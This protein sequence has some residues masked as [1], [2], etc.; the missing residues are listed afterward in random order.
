MILV[1]LSMAVLMGGC[2]QETATG[3]PP[4]RPVRTVIAAKSE[5]GQSVLLTGQVLAEKEIA[6]PFRIGGRIIERKAGVGDRVKPDQVLAKLD[7]RNELNA[8]R[9]ARAALSAAE[10]RLTQDAHRRRPPHLLSLLRSGLHPGLWA[11]RR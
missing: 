4:P 11:R 9:S 2:K 10:G 5:L 1:G 3:T 7:P 6:L 8:L